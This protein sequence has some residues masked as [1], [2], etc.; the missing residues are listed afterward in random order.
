MINAVALVVILSFDLKQKKEGKRMEK[1][2]NI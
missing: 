1:E 2:E